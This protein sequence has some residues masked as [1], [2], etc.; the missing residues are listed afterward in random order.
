[1]GKPL[2]KLANCAY[3]SEKEKVKKKKCQNLRN[4]TINFDDYFIYYYIL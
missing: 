2:E 1:M 4:F 3:Q